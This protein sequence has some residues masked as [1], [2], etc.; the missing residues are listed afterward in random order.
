M[1]VSFL[2]GNFLLPHEITFLWGPHFIFWLDLIL[3]Y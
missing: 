3:L 2:T 1:P